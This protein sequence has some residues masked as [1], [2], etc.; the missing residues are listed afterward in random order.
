ME[1]NFARAI[2][3]IKAQTY[4]QFWPIFGLG[5]KRSLSRSSLNSGF[6]QFLQVCKFFR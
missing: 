1:A 3:R 4:G 5:A 2:T 6:G